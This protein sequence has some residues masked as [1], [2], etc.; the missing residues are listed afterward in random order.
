MANAA[1]PQFVVTLGHPTYSQ[2]KALVNAPDQ[3]TAQGL[4]DAKVEGTQWFV[5]SVA[6]L[7]IDTE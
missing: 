6:P 7:V 2:R 5:V 3:A 1:L 4:A